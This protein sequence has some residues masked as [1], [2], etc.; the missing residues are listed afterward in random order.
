MFSLM[1]RSNRARLLPA[2]LVPCSGSQLIPPGSRLAGLYLL[3]GSVLVAHSPVAFA[4]ISFDT[5]AGT[6]AYESNTME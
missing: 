1:P 5:F 4:M 6:S 2:T 3:L